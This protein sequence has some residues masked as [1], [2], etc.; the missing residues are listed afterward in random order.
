MFVAQQAARNQQV[1]NVW[2]SKNEKEGATS[3][4]QVVLQW[5]SVVA[6]YEV[7]VVL[8]GSFEWLLLKD[9]TGP[10]VG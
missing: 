10:L 8:L 9:F 1:D 7:L 5:S 3:D 2:L 4:L 6:L